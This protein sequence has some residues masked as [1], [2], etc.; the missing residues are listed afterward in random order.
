MDVTPLRAQAKPMRQ[1][2]Q[3]FETVV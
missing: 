3:L 1:M 2:K